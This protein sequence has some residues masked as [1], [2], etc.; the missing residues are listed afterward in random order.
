MSLNKEQM[1][2]WLWNSNFPYSL[3]PYLP[4]LATINPFLNG[5]L[6]PFFSQPFPS[7]STDLSPVNSIEEKPTSSNSPKQE[8]S[9]K[10]PQ[11]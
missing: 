1:N 8:S 7:T 10:R 4:R 3:L 6:S 9:T 5:T 2:N 11:Q